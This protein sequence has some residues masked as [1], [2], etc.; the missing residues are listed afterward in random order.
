MA[1]NALILGAPR[2][3]TSLTSAIFARQGYYVGGAARPAIS[4]GDDYNPYGYFEADDLIERNV[5]C[6]RRVAYSC[7]N[8]W[9]FD[10]ISAES[11][12][13]IGRL[14][15]ELRDQQLLDDYNCRSPW[16]WKDPR[17]CITLPYWAQLLNWH[18]VGVVFVE[19]S[20]DD[21]VWSFHRKGWCGGSKAER[22]ATLA[23]IHQ[24][25]DAAKAALH[26]F[27]IPHLSVR[28][29]DFSVRP[30]QLANQ[31]NECFDLNLSA[32]DLNY[33]SDL[34]HSTFRGRL[35]GYGRIFL[36]RM[37]RG[38]VARCERVVPRRLVRAVF[39]ERKHLTT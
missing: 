5:E 24:H 28:Y 8:S 1:K 35:A 3:G 19:R 7:H 29:E 38:L 25:T 22:Q 27:R 11:Q 32:A 23:R 26:K 34:N 16:L 31:I 14:Q 36:K 37:P 9:L 2:S 17:M 15:P 4:Q 20:A 33:Q 6:F 10:E 30:E 12:Q 18:R 39:P 13:L 21:V